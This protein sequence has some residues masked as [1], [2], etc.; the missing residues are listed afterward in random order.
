MLYSFQII[1][2][3]FIRILEKTEQKRQS[4]MDTRHRTTAN[5]TKNE[6]QNSKKT[7][8]M[9]PNEKPVSAQVLVNK[10]PKCSASYVHFHISRLC[11]LPMESKT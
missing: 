1:T 7:R 4:R 9:H 3:G 10:F 5:K 6:T 11:L 2:H 8:R